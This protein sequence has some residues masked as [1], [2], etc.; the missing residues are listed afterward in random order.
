MTRKRWL[1]IIPI[2]V[3]MYTISFV[4]RTNVSLA[5]DRRISTLL[6]ELAMDERMKGAAAGIFFLGYLLLQVPGGYLAQRWS[7]KKLISLCLLGWGACAMSCGLAHSF[8][9]FAVARFFLGFAESSVFPATMVLLS[10]WFPPWERVRATALWSVCQP[11]AVAVSSPLTGWCLD[12]FGWRTMLILEGALPIL[13]LPLW[14]RFMFDHPHEAKWLP[15][16]E[17]AFIEKAVAEEVVSLES[18]KA[19]SLWRVLFRW[20]V[21]LMIVI[22]M[23]AA[24]DGYGCMTF[25]TSGLRD[26]KFT[27]LEYGVLFAIP[28]L[29]TI[30]LM[31]LNSWHSDKTRERRGH[32][33]LALGLS[34][35][36]LI[37]SVLARHDFWLSY[38]FLCFAIPG[39]VSALGPFFAIPAEIFPRVFLGPLIGA[40]GGIGNLG[41]F[42]GPYFIGW[43][44]DIY[45]SVSV[46]FVLI[47]VGMLAAAA[48]SLLLPKVKQF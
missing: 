45:H 23:I 6:E 39:P 40:V 24:S 4:D 36:C 48:L 42:I 16:A 3:I 8:R 13:L 20:D 25:F 19:V 41:G 15:A 47:G 1:R 9:Q 37:F 22:W 11:L 43:L 12:S 35:A 18:Q 46:P 26:R 33:M 17:C 27:G 44:A 31:V 7:A 38:A 2:A 29:V 28:Y 14:W 10:H 34:G 5:L 21:L 30:P 32:V